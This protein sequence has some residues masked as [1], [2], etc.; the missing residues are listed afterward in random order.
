M[1]CWGWELE[2]WFGRLGVGVIECEIVIYFGL[3]ICWLGYGVYG[4]GEEFG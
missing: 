2:G 4:G 3:D 1:F